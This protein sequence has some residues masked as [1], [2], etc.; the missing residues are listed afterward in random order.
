MLRRI[1][2]LASTLSLLLSA[3]TIALWVRSNSIHDRFGMSTAA[4]RYTLHSADGRIVLAGPPPPAPAAAEAKAR[5]I[6]SQIRNRDVSWEVYRQLQNGH[7]LVKMIDPRPVHDSPLSRIDLRDGNSPRR[8][9]LLALDEPDRFVAAHLSLMYSQRPMMFGYSQITRPDG[10]FDLDVGGLRVTL[11]PGPWDQPPYD[12]ERDS[13][14]FAR[15][16]DDPR[17]WQA[18]ASQ[19]PAIR[20]QWHDALDVRLASCPDWAV[21]LCLL[22]APV[23][24]TCLM[25]RRRSRRNPNLCPR[26]HYDLRATPDRCPECGTPVGFAE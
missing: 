12:W 7:P 20:S 15:W 3:A 26:C 16:C 11:Q 23:A 4:G 24:W 1:F 2:P 21:A 18:A 9:L 6:V 5:A 14:Q 13:G 22:A 25:L 19:L 10:G 8:S 17:F